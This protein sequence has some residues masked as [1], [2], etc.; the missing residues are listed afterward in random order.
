MQVRASHSV[1]KVI[2]FYYLIIENYRNYFVL[3]KSYNSIIMILF[4]YIYTTFY[5]IVHS[6]VPEYPTSFKRGYD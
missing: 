1:I 4:W 3:S 6:I 5:Y 2:L